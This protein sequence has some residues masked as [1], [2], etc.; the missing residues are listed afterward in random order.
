MLQAQYT[1]WSSTKNKTI[2]QK[3]EQ[4]NIVPKHD[5][6]ESRTY[7]AGT[8]SFRPLKGSTER[9]FENGLGVVMSI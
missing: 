3:V 5:N 7:T 2:Y 9:K 8:E 4:L 1:M 6:K